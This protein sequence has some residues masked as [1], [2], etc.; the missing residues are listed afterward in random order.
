M[1][2]FESTSTPV[3]SMH[4]TPSSTTQYAFTCIFFILLSTIERSLLAV[5]SLLEARWRS[6]ALQ[7]GYIRSAVRL[8]EESKMMDGEAQSIRSAKVTGTRPWRLSVD[9]PRAAL[10]VV[11]VAVAYLLYVLLMSLREKDAMLTVL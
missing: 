7:R 5:R 4:W 2:F 10:C 6:Q 8:D 11:I 1:V 9:L 3:Y